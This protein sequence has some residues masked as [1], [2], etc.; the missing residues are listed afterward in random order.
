MKQSLKKIFGHYHKKE[1]TDL[2]LTPSAV[3][4]PIYYEEDQV[5]IL[6]TRRSDLVFH[7]KGQICF[8]GGSYKHGDANLLQTALRESEEEIG[9]K[10]KDVEILGELDDIST[11]TSGYSISPFI[12][13][14]P[15]PYQF[16]IN[17]QEISRIFS[18]P[19]T[20]LMDDNILKYWHRGGGQQ[21]QP[22]YYYHYEDHIIWGVTARILSQFLELLKLESG[23]SS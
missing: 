14:I 22:S 19:L 20:K 15:H 11:T 16:K 3:I 12:A 4:L 7:H 8:P 18:I 21:C 2:S 9:L 1:N 5:H 23:A 17:Y 6:F 13:L 10:S